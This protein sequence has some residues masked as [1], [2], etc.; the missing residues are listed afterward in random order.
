M[1]IL[2]GLL[3]PLIAL[4]TVCAAESSLRRRSQAT[5][6]VHL[7]QLAAAMVGIWTVIALG[8]LVLRTGN[9]PRTTQIAWTGLEKDVTPASPELAIG[10][11]EQNAVIGWPNGTFAPSLTVT[12]DAG[13]NQA[14]ISIARGGAFVIRP[15]SNSLVNGVPLAEGETKTFDGYRFELDGRSTWAPYFVRTA[16]F[17][18][19]G[20]RL[21]VTAP[22]G[23]KVADFTM[24][25]PGWLPWRNSYSLLSLEY[26]NTRSD[27]EI[28]PN[29]VYENWSRP[30][31]VAIT[32]RGLRIL[33]RASIARTPCTLPCSLRLRWRSGSLNISIDRQ[34]PSTLR[35]R[36][37]RPWRHVSPLPN[38]Q[39][40]GGRQLIVTRQAVPG[41]YAF[42]LPIGGATP[43]PRA[44]LW[45][46]E[47]SGVPRF[48]FAAEE[49]EPI[50][51][52]KNESSAVTSEV[53]VRSGSHRFSFATSTDILHPL[54]VVIHL[55]LALLCFLAGL[56][57]VTAKTETEERWIVCG[58]A[59]VLFDVLVFRVAL[60]IRYAMQP[61]FVD[62][63]SVKGLVLS[64]FAA[65]VVPSLILLEA[66][67][68]RDSTSRPLRKKEG[69]R[70]ALYAAGY[71]AA[72]VIV[73][74][75]QLGVAP[76]LWPALPTTLKP[77][78]SANAVMIV[79][80]TVFAA[81][82][83][84]LIRRAYH[85]TGVRHVPWLSYENFA[86]RAGVFWQAVADH[87]H[88]AGFRW[89][90]AV[91]GAFALLFLILK[92]IPGNRLIQEVFAPLILTL[93]PAL[94]WLSSARHFRERAGTRT[95]PGFMA[96]RG[97]WLRLLFWAALTVA[98]PVVLFP[99]AIHD[100][101]SMLATFAVFLPLLGILFAAERAL[102]PAVVTALCFVGAFVAAGW[103]YLHIE[104]MYPL[105]K[106]MNVAGNVPARMIA[107]KRDQR[108]QQDI[109]R[110]SR[111]LEEAYTHTWENK[112]IAHEGGV[113]G[114]GF[115]NAPTRR[116]HV[117][118]D[119]LQF[120]S[121]FSFFVVSDYGMV[122]G[123][124]LLVI[125][126][127]PIA[128]F[129]LVTRARL[130]LPVAFGLIISAAFF[131]EA[132]F[133]AAMNT[134]TMPFAG[135]NLPLLSVHSGSDMLKWLCLFL[136]ATA[137]PF[138]VAPPA[139]SAGRP[140]DPMIVSGW[141]RWITWGVFA[142]LPLILLSV[143]AGGTWKNVKDKQLGEPFTWDAMLDT[144][145]TLTRDG[146]LKLNDRHE[147][148]P[149]SGIATEESLLAN[150][151]NAFNQLPLL[152]RM[153]ERRSADFLPRLLG[154][155][156]P[157]AYQRVL[158]NEATQ[159]LDQPPPYPPLFRLN[160]QP[161][162]VDDFG[163]LQLIGPPYT[164]EPN[165]EFNTR[166]SFR[167]YPTED[168]LPRIFLA[169]QLHGT[170]LLQGGAFS[171]AVP[172]RAPRPY[173][174]RTVQLSVTGTELQ[175]TADTNSA[176]PRGD[177]ML[178]GPDP[179]GRIR[180]EP[181]FRFTI[182]NG[183]YLYI[184]NQLPGPLRVRRKKEE[185]SIPS[186]RRLQV[187]AGDRV[188]LP[189][190]TGIDPAFTV[191]ESDPPALVGPAWVMGRWRVTYDPNGPLPWTAYL[192]TA[193]EREWERIGTVK[194][195][196]RYQ[197][198]TLDP[199][200]QRAAQNTAAVHGRALHQI[201]LS[202]YAGVLS[203]VSP[204]ASPAAIERAVEHAHP[205]RVALSVISLPDGAVLA[206]AGWPRMSSGSIGKQ[207]T[208]FD[209][210][211]PPTDWI[212]RLA[213]SFI[214]ARYGGDR[215]FDRIEMG[216]STKP[217]LAAAA[218]A[219][220]PRLDQQL[221]V[222]GGSEIETEVFGIPI[223]GKGWEAHNSP[224]WTNFERYLAE[225]DNRYQVRLGFLALAQHDA[226]GLV[227]TEQRRSPSVRESMDGAAEWQHYPYFPSAMK[228]SSQRPDE[229]VRIDD[230]PFAQTIRSMYG[231]GVRRGDAR[232]ARYSFW[233]M[234]GDDDASPPPVAA[235]QPGA[236]PAYPVTRS[237]DVISPELAN[238]GFD[239]IV[240]PRQYVS[241]LLGG[242]ENRWANVDFA[243]GFGTAVTG[244]PV[245]P[246][247][248]QSKT[249]PAPPAARRHFPDIAV[250]LR[251]GLQGVI[252]HGTAA[253]ER[254]RILAPE[255]MRIPGVQMYAKTG[256]LGIAGD[257]T[258]TSRL[259]LAIIR[260]ADEPNG[261]VQKGLVLS[262]VA[263]RA[264]MGNA[265][266]WLADYVTQ[267]Q[268]QL[269]RYL[270]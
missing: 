173:E 119:T 212:D 233:T 155:R 29:R 36:F 159:Q 3:V 157:N 19:T 149:A 54:S 258:T 99:V 244:H 174:D 28:K 137:T 196:E 69:H 126:T 187:F 105:L 43:D 9:W 86:E 49:N 50:Y 64:L 4:V 71:L 235:P 22:S 229:M 195:K 198:L 109:L 217:L 169:D 74:F 224:R 170:F 240:H 125:Y 98:F 80:I 252:Q 177:V 94:L 257:G 218:L 262:L 140:N 251:P 226:N 114:M 210:W 8:V 41:D 53:E 57:L 24:S 205:P 189:A 89:Y 204:N 214:R 165:P 104:S 209:T 162:K 203:R 269:A 249:V 246:H 231:V 225:S 167:P 265:T 33:D 84:W 139:P 270:Q 164:I 143:L 107:F 79:I 179:H 161:E 201:R 110:F 124:S 131:A 65:T 102:K 153:G 34:P 96:H 123:L 135:R 238:L 197:L 261:V 130:S 58:L 188:H 101:G 70:A 211:C 166:I 60:S 220:D 208:Q 199:A 39:P 5:W 113:T 142:A 168:D 116:S 250:K 219:I 14:T 267:N 185:L 21:R 25:R 147:I 92:L 66:R 118:Q 255:L 95:N 20:Y 15:E 194:A 158:A 6:M 108:A 111:S 27:E 206:M 42:V 239:Y 103:G 40:G 150:Q 1:W 7:P 232:A 175:L 202:R 186:R 75:I 234:N 73:A 10:G 184:E 193:L 121:V 77:G 76:R 207:C 30:V 129:L 112:A 62:Q 82:A 253:F 247:I 215:N 90:L 221:H 213:P 228:F 55:T 26:L 176:G 191:Y 223:R 148:V 151:I 259:V 178:R 48:A 181:Y 132:W 256:T 47:D 85:G 245:L 133:H 13:T 248:I 88:R 97:S 81:R 23:E 44:P 46:N 51:G 106:S 266:S 192:T 18:F 59:A 200:L 216:S 63:I 222:A 61:Q 160:P 100:P 236:P 91:L 17:P 163:I 264:Q 182:E 31:L 67:L 32:N 144:V 45:I 230:S 146:K 12:P 117:R 38:P 141:R 237:F 136:V 138:W 93:L 11:P 183:Q 122:G 56:V 154:V 35:V 190:Q 52:G 72:I 37:A 2:L 145:S 152:E 83:I 172:R 227:Q 260:W 241:L 16:L 87:H 263:E 242:N 180:E 171:I 134:G 127:I 156:T 243:G 115:G 68:R 128:L 120:D 78:T 268:E 254:G